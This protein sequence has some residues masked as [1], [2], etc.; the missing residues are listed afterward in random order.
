MPKSDLHLRGLRIVKPERGWP[1]GY[2]FTLPLV[3]SAPEVKFTAPVTFFVGE[4]GSGKS[5]LLEALACAIG[6]V[7]AGT[8]PVASDP[9]LAPAR[10]LARHMR[11]SW[12]KK[13]RKGLFLRAE[14]FFGYAKRMAEMRAALAQDLRDM[15]DEYKNRSAYA[16]QLAQG[17]IRGQIYDIDRRYGEGGLDARSHGEGFLD[18]F[19]TR[20]VP[21]GV[22]LLDEPEAPLSP[23]RQLSLL[24]LLKDMVAQQSQFIIATHSPILMAFPDA[25]IYRFNADS[26]S[27]LSQRERASSSHPNDEG[28]G[29]QVIERV[30][31][32]DVEHVKITRDFLANPQRFL[33]HL[34]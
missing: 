7:T 23:L 6:S 3:R 28:I 29:E 22:Y 32:D 12:T 14:D 2:P 21:A 24:T 5:T 19:R 25:V 33:Q 16:K 30:A 9:T 15:D 8:A 1:A 26:H 10:E 20:F 4:N 34:M 27:T 31:F 11:L 17:A 13:T 18:F